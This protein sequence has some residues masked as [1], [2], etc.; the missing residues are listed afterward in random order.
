MHIVYA[1]SAKHDP[2]V[3]HIS[4]SKVETL[5]G[6]W[7]GPEGPLALPV[8]CDECRTKNGELIKRRNTAPESGYTPCA[9]RDCMDVAISSD[10]SKPEL[11]AECEEAGCEPAAVLVA[12]LVVGT[13]CQR[14]D[15]YDTECV[16]GDGPCPNGCRCGCESGPY[17][18]ACEG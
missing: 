1:S 6:K 3:R 11:C 14:D 17:E 10:T 5:C 2:T 12:D 16:N 15:A 4:Y 13:D 18:C 7:A 9:C 8:N